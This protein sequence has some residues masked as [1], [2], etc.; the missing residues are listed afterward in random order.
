[1][2]NNDI[3][4]RLAKMIADARSLEHELTDHQDYQSIRDQIQEARVKLEA[5]ITGGTFQTKQ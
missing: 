1:M 5:V 2:L 4:T 3:K